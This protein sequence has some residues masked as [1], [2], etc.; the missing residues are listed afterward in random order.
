MVQ[1]A[2]S[3]Q[4]YITHLFFINRLTATYLKRPH[5]LYVRGALIP[6]RPASWKGG[7]WANRKGMQ[8]NHIKAVLWEAG[9]RLWKNMRFWIII[10]LR[11]DF[12][13]RAGKLKSDSLDCIKIFN[14]WTWRA[15]LK[16]SA[17]LKL[18]FNKIFP[19]AA[20]RTN[21]KETIFTQLSLKT[22][23]CEIGLA[24]CK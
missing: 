2:E 24:N 23:L 18:V 3:H 13:G 21:L 14:C 10:P 19:L 15:N 4:I 16:G 8:L 17:I 7:R 5:L 11:A 9:W 20:G 12:W 22:D 6:G 1:V